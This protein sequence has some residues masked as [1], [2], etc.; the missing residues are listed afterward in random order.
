MPSKR[1]VLLF[2]FKVVFIIGWTLKLDAKV[3][4]SNSAKHF[5]LRK[6]YYIC[7]HRI[8]KR[9]NIILKISEKLNHIYT[10]I[11]PDFQ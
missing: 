6:I 7:M 2:W 10:K 9:E 11:K 4:Q 1:T 5:F 3:A 8:R